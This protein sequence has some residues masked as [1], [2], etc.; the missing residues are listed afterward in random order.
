MGGWVHKPI[1]VISLKVMSRQIN[2]IKIIT[3]RKEYVLPQQ[4]SVNKWKKYEEPKT[5]VCNSILVC[6]YA[7]IYIIME[8]MCV[9]VSVRLCITEGRRPLT[10]DKLWRK[11]TFDGRWH[12]FE[13]H[14]QRKT[15]YRE[16]SRHW[17]VLYGPCSH[18][19]IVALI[20]NTTEV[21]D[22]G[23]WDSNAS[24]MPFPLQ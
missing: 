14:L 21:K 7:T 17:S 5:H 10:E 23:Y 6:E 16:V 1:L 11:T 4:E 24:Y 22:L 13:H 19:Y 12:L 18:F 8:S 9:C 2:K 3:D 20:P 15:T